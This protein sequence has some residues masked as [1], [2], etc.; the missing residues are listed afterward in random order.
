MF[1]ITPHADFASLAADWERLLGASPVRGPFLSWRWHHLWWESFA[2]PGDELLLLA[3]CDAE[4]PAG[5]APLYRRDGRLAFAAG[6]DVSDYLDLL[7][8]PGGETAVAGALSR[9]LLDLR[10]GELALDSLA[11]DSNVL[12][13]LAPAL[14]SAGLTADAQ[15]QEVCPVVELPADWES[16]VAS[17]SKKDRHELRRKY[18]R[19]EGAGPTEYLALVDGQIGPREVEDFLT[20]HRLSTPD[21]A[22]FMDEQM[23]G[24]FR[25]LFARFAHDGLLRL[26]FLEYDAKR[27]AAALLFDWGESFLLYNSGYDP[28]YAPLS[29]GLLLKAHC[30][31]DAI[32]LGRRRF[33][34]LR[35]NER[36]K[37]DLGAVDVPVYG[38]RVVRSD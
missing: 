22:V 23:Q 18:R 19:L 21:K 33:D 4:G 7:V 3:L 38:L 11:P 2:R 34:F 5:I 29:V 24:F 14:G 10:W 9:Y 1:S 28:A 20:L 35:G 12:R 32:S 26:Y 6:T 37:Y 25:Q 36:Y 27:V 13:Y 17:L 16:Y 30:L 8:R 15:Q 31:R